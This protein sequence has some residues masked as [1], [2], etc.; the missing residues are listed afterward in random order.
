[1]LKTSRFEIMLS[2]LLFGC[3]LSFG[4]AAFADDL[5]TLLSGAKSMGEFLASGAGAK[6]YKD[7][8]TVLSAVSGQPMYVWK[9]PWGDN[10]EGVNIENDSTNRCRLIKTLKPG[11]TSVMQTRHNTEAL[12]SRYATDLYIE[13]IKTEFEIDREKPVAPVKHA[14]EHT[15]L[16]REVL[17]RL[18]NIAARLNVI[19]SLE[20]RTAALDNIAKLSKVGAYVFKDYE[21]NTE[22]GTCAI[23]KATKSDEGE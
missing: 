2:L 21:Y 20:A 16:K 8:V 3:F 14:A 17:A 12:L 18:A 13:A 4:R 7:K 6:Y 23:P 22:D 19:V 1:M 5:D 11:E 10:E 9:A 15:L